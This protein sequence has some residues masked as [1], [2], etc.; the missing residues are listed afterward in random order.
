MLKSEKERIK[1]EHIRRGYSRHRVER[2]KPWVLLNY[3]T[4]D[5]GGQ[6]DRGLPSYTTDCYW[7]RWARG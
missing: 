3:Y 7:G 5:K 1:E 2:M 4:S 6:H